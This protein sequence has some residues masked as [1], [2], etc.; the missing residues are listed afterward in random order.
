M[1]KTTRTVSKNIVLR[2][3]GKRFFLIF[4]NENLAN[5]IGES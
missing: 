1:I 2:V 5:L 3:Q 4:A